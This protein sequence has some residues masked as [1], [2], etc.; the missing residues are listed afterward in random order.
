M[1]VTATAVPLL[2]VVYG[3]GNVIICHYLEFIMSY[4]SAI[5]S[6]MINMRRRGTKAY[7]SSHCNE[8]FFREIESQ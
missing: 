2:K 4:L 1:N 6:I 3:Y 8:R 5:S 7:A